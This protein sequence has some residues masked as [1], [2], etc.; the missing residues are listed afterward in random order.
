MIILQNIN[1]FNIRQQ[2]LVALKRTLHPRTLCAKKN[3]FTVRR[4]FFTT[5]FQ[6]E[7][8]ENNE[9]QTIRT[10]FVFVKSKN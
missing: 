7:N 10:F 1:M 3:M 5:L 8:L 4:C 2:I 9:F 6:F